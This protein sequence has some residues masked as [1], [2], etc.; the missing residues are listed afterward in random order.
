MYILVR[1]LSIFILLLQFVVIPKVFAET[2]L[3]F[4]GSAAVPNPQTIRFKFASPHENGLPIYGPGGRGLTY[5]WRAYPRSQPGYYTAFFWANDDGQSNLNNFLW[6]SSGGADTYYGAHPYPRGGGSSTTPHDWEISISQIDPTNGAVEYDRWHTQALRV[7]EGVDGQKHHEFYWDL[8]HTDASH[9]VTYTAPASYGNI[10]PPAPAL[11]WGDAPWQPGNE[12][13]NG[14]L[15]GIQI[16]N[17]LLSLSEIQAEIN[18]PLS[19]AKG[20]SNIW[21]LNT[22][23][24]PSDISDK[25]GRG[26]HPVWVGPLRPDLYTDG[27]GSEPTTVATPLISPEGGNFIDSVMVSLTVDTSGA[28]IYYTTDNSIPETTSLFYSG[29]FS[30]FSSTTVKAR[31]F[32]TGMNSSTVAGQEYTL[33]TDN[34]PPAL[35]SAAAFG[36]PN[37]VEVIFTE[38][39]DSATAIATTNYAISNSVSVSGASLS[40]D[41]K[42]VTLNTSTLSQ[43]I[44]YTIT[45]NNVRDQIGNVIDANSQIIFYFTPVDVSLGLAAYWPFEEGAGSTTADVTGN[46]YTGNISGS[47]WNT[48]GKAGNALDFDGNNDVVTTGSWDIMGNT[49]TLALWFNADSFSISDARLISK[50][51]GTAEQDHYWMLST[52]DDN[53]IKLRFRLKIDGITQ[54][55]IA[56]SDILPTGQW[57]HI[58]AVYDGSTMKLFR[59]GTLVGNLDKNGSLSVNEDAEVTIGQNPD[60]YG[61]WDGLL[62]EVRIYNRALTAEEIAVLAGIGDQTPAP[63]SN[64][65]IQPSN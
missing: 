37:R 13:W 54:T 56:G 47:T 49:L 52:I 14:I 59:D 62:D 43:D 23:P 11:T 45:V 3:D 32:K 31:A 46:G 18:S 24:T 50:S 4:P 55:L 60:G 64:L 28:D 26:H 22:N 48:N 33:T 57:V 27:S 10:N 25:S 41:K 9:R 61:S 15:R 19:T 40:G 20:S 8:P 53:G 21:Y 36:N 44:P 34:T 63:P 6:T 2:G 58:A 1:H 30:V 12:V 7:W 16:Y 17:D 35:N 42:T 39:V 5:I 65:Q 38:E 51:I 29:P